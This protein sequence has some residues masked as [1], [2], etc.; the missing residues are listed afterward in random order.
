MFAKRTL[1]L[2]LVAVL[3]NMAVVF[4]DVAINFPIKGS[5]VNA[6]ETTDV[7]WVAGPNGISP[8][9]NVD[10]VLMEGTDPNNLKTIKTFEQAK[11]SDLKATITI[12][13][14]LST[15]GNYVIRVGRNYSHYFS[16]SG[17]SSSSSQSP[18]SSS[19]SSSTSA[20]PSSTT[21]ST[22]TITNTPTKTPI[23]MPSSGATAITPNAQPLVLTSSLVAL[24]PVAILAIWGF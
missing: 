24:L 13:A 23:K 21:T 20:T 16:I 9:A 5:S 12:P 4:A 18:T 19:S 3:A 8:N 17:S 2:T 11:E 7:T 10:V 22:T 1:A 6:G 14:D 15:S